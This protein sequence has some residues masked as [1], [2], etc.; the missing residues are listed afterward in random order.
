MVEVLN[1]TDVEN[2]INGENGVYLLHECYLLHGMYPSLKCDNLLS[3]VVP[4]EKGSEFI[5]R[6]PDGQGLHCRDRPWNVCN[7]VVVDDFSIGGR[8]LYFYS[9]VV[10]TSFCGKNCV[11]S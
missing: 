1:V 8:Q 9:R 10:G 2:V 6:Q 7:Y 5:Q 3:A 11:L 4:K